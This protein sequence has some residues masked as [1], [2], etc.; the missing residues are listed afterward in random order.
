MQVLITRASALDNR[1]LPAGLIIELDDAAALRLIALGV[2]AQTASRPAPA[3]PQP[4]KR[5]RE[6]T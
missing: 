6:G 4:A 5:R 1:I 2:A 3:Q